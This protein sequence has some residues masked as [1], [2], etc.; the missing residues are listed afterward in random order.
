MSKHSKPIETKAKAK[1]NPPASGKK[2]FLILGAGLLLAVILAYFLL[3]KKGSTGKVD[4]TDDSGSEPTL[5]A[6][7]PLLQLLS[8]NE[9]GIDFENQILED[10][11]INIFSNINQYNGGGVAVADINN[12]QLPDIYFVNTSGKNRLYLNQGNFTFKDI[13]DAAGVGSE[14]G[15]ET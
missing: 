15:F 14:D 13:T 5:T 8:A 10:A 7:Q 6:K 11:N 4:L 12:D 3:S 1:P 9:T 2:F